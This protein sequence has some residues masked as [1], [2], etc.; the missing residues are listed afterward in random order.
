ML[1]GPSG[2]NFVLKAGNAQS[3]KLVT[4]WDGVR[5]RGYSPMK[6]QGAIILGTG[7]DGSNGGTGTFFEGAITT[8]VPSNAVDD[9]IQANIVA[10][11]YGSTIAVAQHSLDYA[12]KFFRF[13]AGYYQSSAKVVISYTL[14]DTRYVGMTVFNQQGR[15]IAVI[16]NGI[17]S[18]G[19][20]EAVWDSKPFP[21][22]IYVVNTSIDGRSGW[23]GRIIAG[24]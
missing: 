18:A 22:S 13:R 6:K 5:P 15:R 23:A 20:H 21:A 7:G 17:R 3:G 11:G 24:K 9:E 4:M 19:R 16:E 8:G 14:E 1:K 2:N 10:V 12:Q